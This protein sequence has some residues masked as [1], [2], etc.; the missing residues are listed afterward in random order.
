MEYAMKKLILFL[1]IFPLVG[2]ATEY[3]I[4]GLVHTSEIKITLQT[5]DDLNTSAIT[6]GY[7]MAAGLSWTNLTDS[8]TNSLAGWWTW[9]ATGISKTVGGQSYFGFKSSNNFYHIVAGT[10]ADQQLVN[11]A[12]NT[13][14]TT[15]AG[16]YVGAGQF[17][18]SAAL[19]SLSVTTNTVLTGNT[20]IP[21]SCKEVVIQTDPR[22][23]SQ[24]IFWR[25]STN[26]WG[27]TFFG[28]NAAAIPMAVPIV[29]GS[30]SISR[31][32]GNPIK[33][34]WLS[35]S[36]TNTGYTITGKQDI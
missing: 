10:S 31:E 20:W 35:A 11:V 4:T 23:S 2:L 34:L 36:G 7:L 6:N 13:T 15:V 32:K 22:A 28:T 8:V 16:T 12:S 29:D 1:L 26:N 9:G 3:S 30:V 33:V 14:L 25:T 27:G 17:Y 18:G 19:A 24:T 5:V 21:F